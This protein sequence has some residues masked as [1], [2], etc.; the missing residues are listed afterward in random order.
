MSANGINTDAI[1][2]VIYQAALCLDD[3]QW[4][5]WLALCDDDFHYEIKAFSPEIRYDMTYLS[6]NRAQVQ[7]MME[8]LPKHNTDHS[9][10]S[11]HTVVYSV[12]LD[13]KSGTAT[14]VSS[15][16]VHQTLLDG[17]NSHVDAG[18]SRLFLVGK[19]YDKFRI[20]DGKVKFTERVVRLN[21]R[22]L[23]KGSHWPI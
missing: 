15:F 10:L 23:D 12:D 5:G 7:S 4:D 21:T 22:R 14:A 20:R 1:K 3:E 16:T 11:R 13:E 8:L 9:P 17:I 6:G 18:E 2:E 19:Y